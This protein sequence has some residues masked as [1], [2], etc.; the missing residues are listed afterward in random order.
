MIRAISP[1]W[2][3]ALPL[4]VSGCFGV[5]CRP[6]PTTTSQSPPPLAAGARGTVICVPGAGG[7]PAIC[8]ALSDT[9]EARGEGL[10]VETFEWTHGNWRILADHVDQSNI[11]YQ[12]A[13]L[14]QRL[15]CVKQQCPTRPV[16]VLAHSAGS[17]VVL[18]AACH[19]PPDSVDRIVFLA[20][21]VSASYDLRPA[22]TCASRGVDVFYS[23]RDRWALGVGTTIFG[24]TD[25]HWGP[26]AG[27]VG[28]Q[29]RPCCR[30]DEALLSKLRQH[31]WHP[32]LTWAGN[33]G[34][35]YGTYQPAFLQAYVLPLL[36]P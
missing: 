22:L 10:Q 8:K 31:P 29:P 5:S 12:G 36:R 7:F 17:A 20:P 13:R 15:V 9:I 23:E 30:A 19:L 2:L 34:G 27:R 26:V 14:A 11:Q 24:S 16:Y 3:V 32:C 6:L 35:H 1:H 25:R 18:A 28:F 33:Y 21:A 4:L